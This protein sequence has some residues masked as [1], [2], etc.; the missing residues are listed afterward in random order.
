ML[1]PQNY[2]AQFFFNFGPILTS[3]DQNLHYMTEI[4]GRWTRE[5]RLSPF[6]IR[7]NY[8]LEVK[9]SERVE[10]LPGVIIDIAE[11]DTVH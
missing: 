3:L 6:N 2:K 8:Y 7:L 11:W 1:C 5:L 4:G 9:G 10:Q